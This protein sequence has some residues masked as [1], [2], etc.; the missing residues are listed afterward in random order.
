MQ[1]LVFAEQGLN[2]SI[3]PTWLLFTSCSLLDP[4][5]KSL[6]WPG[7]K[8]RQ[9]FEEESYSNARYAYNCLHFSDTNTDDL[10]EQIFSSR[11]PGSPDD[12]LACHRLP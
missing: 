2:A 6:K 9:G 1:H 5:W 7:S 4:S 10:V 8:A 11:P 3:P 12:Y